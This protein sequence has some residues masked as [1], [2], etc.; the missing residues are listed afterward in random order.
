MRAIDPIFPMPTFEQEFQI[1][2]QHYRAGRIDAAR[3]AGERLLTRHSTSPGVLQLLGEIA[4]CL[5]RLGDAESLLERAISSNPQDPLSHWRLGNVLFAMRKLDAAAQHYIQALNLKQDFWEASA[6]LGLLWRSRGCFQQAREQ[7]EQSLKYQPEAT[8]VF[9]Y[10]LNTVLSLGDLSTIDAMSAKIK[11][12]V[13]SC[14]N[15]DRERDFGALAA[16]IYMSPLVSLSKQNTDALMHKMDRL[17][18]KGNMAPLF[19]TA[20][21]RHKLRIG[22]VSRDFGDHPIS[23]VT[24]GLFGHHDR[25][26]FHTIAY[27]VATRPGSADRDYIKAIQQDCDDFVDLS[28]LTVR[29]AAE[30]IAADDVQILVNLG[31][32]MCLWSLEVFSFRPAPI[33]VYWLGHGGELGLS[34]MDYVI[35]DAVVIP[36][37]EEIGFREKVVRLPEAYHCADTPS[38]SDRP[39][40]RS[41]HGLD[42]NAFVFCTFNNPNKIDSK[43]FDAWMNI[44]RR[45]PLSQIWLS[46]PGGENALEHNLRAE[47]QQ[48][49]ISPS[50]LVFAP[51]LPDKSLHFARHRLADLFLDTFVYTAATTAIDALWAGLPIVTRRG[52]DFYS[53]IG[54]TLVTHVG[55]GDMICDSTQEYEDRAVYFANNRSALSAVRERLSRN[56]HREPLFDLPRFVRHLED[57]YREMW[58]RHLSGAA[59]ASFNVS[60]RPR[61][62]I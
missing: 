46:N 13:E 27:S 14:I 20:Q 60:A 58:R 57:A 32:Y 36:P 61:A 7:F 12:F 16:L 25:E 49:G 59:P 19:S 26:R 8:A 24:R 30:R 55:L 4:T 10:L 34:F 35:A 6:S 21:T 18:N 3:I 44:M 40:S 51:R 54:A 5:G 48:R 52:N 38:V 33:Q 1:A 15:N 23:H 22:Y 2:V 47:A 53:R 50:R 41:E 29:Q 43:V 56:L 28:G 37:G 62:G 17:M 39:Q 31:G 42:D 11:S 9:C 45:V